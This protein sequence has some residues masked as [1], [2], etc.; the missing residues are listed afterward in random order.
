[1]DQT[2]D[3][4]L[5]QE[6]QHQEGQPQDQ[7]NVE[8]THA[9]LTAKD[10]TSRFV[11]LALLKTLLDNSE[12][13]RQDVETVTAIWQAISPKFLDRL[14]KTGSQPQSRQ[15]GG[16]GKSGQEMLDLAVAVL[17]TFVT[18]LPEDAIR[19]K[20]AVGRMPHLVACL[21]YSSE[22]T[23]RLALEN[24]LTLVSQP[25][26]AQEFNQV[27]DLTPLVEIAPSHQLA[28]K[29]LQFA[30]I[31]DM[32]ASSSDKAALRS[33]LDKTIGHLVSSFKGTDAVTLLEFLADLLRSLDPEVCSF[34]LTPLSSK[35]TSSSNTS[36]AHPTEP[37]L[38][39]FSPQLHP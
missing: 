11:G 9:L 14:I 1:M 17:H 38:A 29:I 20:R 7:F 3:P 15:D 39:P 13:V 37:I 5:V 19:E 4:R 27:E 36:S 25:E 23:T 35:Q 18:L 22:E 28:L 21:M 26:G 6:G 33:K 16:G 8:K 2:T 12:Q 31:G 10:D 32:L 24:L 30:W 34:P